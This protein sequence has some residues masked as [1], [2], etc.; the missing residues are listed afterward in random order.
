MVFETLGSSLLDLIK[1]Y[2]YRGMPLLV[3]K[4]ITQQVLQGVR[5]S[6]F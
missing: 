4:Y 5:Q 1:L 6:V 3:V 2:N